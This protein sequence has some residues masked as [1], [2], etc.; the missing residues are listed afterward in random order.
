MLAVL[1]LGAFHRASALPQSGAP[2]SSTLPSGIVPAPTGGLPQYLTPMPLRGP[3][4]LTGGEAAVWRTIG[5]LFTTWDNGVDAP[6]QQEGTA[7]V[8]TSPGHNMIV[9]GGQRLWNGTSEPLTVSFA[10][11]YVNGSSPYGLWDAHAWA[12]PGDYLTGDG[13]A[14]VGFALL[15]PNK[16][17]QLIQDVTGAQ[18]LAFGAA[19]PGLVV[20][21]LGYPAADWDIVNGTVRTSSAG[22]ELFIC[23]ATIFPSDPPGWFGAPGKIASLCNWTVGASGVPWLISG[24]GSV[25]GV[26]SGAVVGPDG[27]FGGL[28]PEN[29]F[30]PFDYAAILDGRAQDLYQQFQNVSMAQHAVELTLANRGAFESITTVSTGDGQAG[31]SVYV[32]A[33]QTVNVTVPLDYWRTFAVRGEALF[34]RH[35][36]YPN[37]ALPDPPVLRFEYG[38]TTMIGFSFRPVD[39]VTGATIPA[40]ATEGVAPWVIAGSGALMLVTALMLTPVVWTLLRYWRAPAPAEDIEPPATPTDD[41]ETPDALDGDLDPPIGPIENIQLHD[42]G[43]DHQG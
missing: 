37:L 5:K 31:N 13:T 7:T 9:M 39:P 2:A 40:Y 1:A 16:D 34:G 8:V 32:R 3:S 23:Q 4:G 25:I 11:G 24:S 17:G 33:G 41:L 19:Q 29:V 20:D 42:F 30:G 43:A 35:K 12:V 27:T 28:G 38:G 22:A 14:D 18:D 10:P 36:T 6:L 21:E 15:A 26:G